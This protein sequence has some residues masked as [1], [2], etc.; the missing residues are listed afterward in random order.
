M[1]SAS[2]S[3]GYSWQRVV[4]HIGWLRTEGVAKLVE[5]DNVN[6]RE[7]IAMAVSRARWRRANPP[8]PG[9]WA[10]TVFLVGLQR[11]GTNMM[12]RG[13]EMSPEFEVHNENDGRAFERFRLRRAEVAPLVE[14][15]RHR[16]VLF[17]P[18]CD[19]H[20]VVDLLDDPQLR[21]EA[22]AIWAVRD[23]DARVRSAVAKFGDANQRALV[24]ISEGRPAEG[25]QAGG[26]VEEDLDL[27][28][29]LQPRQLSAESGAALLWYLRNRLFFTRG[30]D[31]RGDVLLASYEAFVDSPEAQ[32]RR[33][34]DFLGVTYRDSLVAHVDARASGVRP[35]LEIHPVVRELCRDLGERLAVVAAA[36]A[37]GR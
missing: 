10:T 18:L 37:P 29:G 31:Q 9:Q 33:L 7:R 32:M 20:D 21:G 6:P 2:S 36:D 14:R 4:R 22:R 25:W 24:E 26:L 28:R 34:C 23:V 19:S 27:I 17:K 13:L 5:E 15:S 8:V 3:I 30:L 1:D 35:P 16:F 12:L 11:S